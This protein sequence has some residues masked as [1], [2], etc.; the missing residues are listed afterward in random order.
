MRHLLPAPDPADVTLVCGLRGTGKSTRVKRSIARWQGVRVLV[1]DPH[2]EYSQ[3]G[4]AREGVELGPLRDRLTVEQLDA[5]PGILD[6]ADLS[7]AVVPRRDPEGL[8]EDF[9]TVVELVVDTGNLV[10]VVDEV[11]LTA[12]SCAERY[13]YLGLQSRHDSVPLVF[14]S[15]RAVHLPP[16]A[17]SQVNRV[18]AHRQIHPAD[19][20]A[21]EE[22]FGDPARAAGVR[23][24]AN[25]ACIP[26]RDTDP[27]LNPKEQS[28]G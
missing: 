5:T 8:A 16:D 2:D 22:I 20:D 3:A 18:F 26:W 19:L 23:R 12:K 15:Q 27:P 25:F 6:A 1:F 14:V 9:R 28:H 13:A 21:L 11:R 7:L 4:D 24:L 10:F 17:R